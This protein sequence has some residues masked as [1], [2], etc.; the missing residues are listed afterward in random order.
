M[1]FTFFF[2]YTNDNYDN[3]L[4]SFFQELETE[5]KG[6][7]TQKASGF[8]APRNIGQGQEWPPELA[9]ALVGCDVLVCVY[10]ADYFQSD[11]CGKE[12]Q[13]FLERRKKYIKDHPNLRPANILPVYWWPVEP[14]PIVVRR[15][16]HNAEPGSLYKQEGLKYVRALNNKD[17]QDTYVSLRRSFARSIRDAA[18][19]HKLPSIAPPKIA[20]VR[21]AFEP[22][23]PLP[24]ADA[25]KAVGPDAVTF[26]FAGSAAHGAQPVCSAAVEASDMEAQQIPF[27]AADSGLLVRIQSSVDRGNVTVLVVDGASLGDPQFAARMQ[28]IDG[29]KLASLATLVVWPNKPQTAI[30]DAL[31]PYAKG[32]PVVYYRNDIDSA[33]ALLKALD[34]SMAV[35]Q[36]DVVNNP[37]APKDQVPSSF[38][39]LPSLPSPGATGAFAHG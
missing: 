21:N 27:N 35:V 17:A 5:V 34:T 29:K 25:R 37:P 15:F 33:E 39:L 11:Y 23:L 31:F 7:M 19:K 14:I 1:P 20:A 18:Q 28:E 8:F 24:D 22:L 3:E 26:V 10:S 9:A 30:A 16:Q 2:S 6:L 36:G 4:L 12:V 32:R 38:S 13:V